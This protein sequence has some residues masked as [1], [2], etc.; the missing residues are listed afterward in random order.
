MWNRAELKNQAKESF[1]RSYWKAVLVGLLC[2]LLGTSPGFE[3]NL[4][5]DDTIMENAAFNFEVSQD[6]LAEFDTIYM[7]LYGDDFEDEYDDYYKNDFFG[8]EEDEDSFYAFSSPSVNSVSAVAIRFVLIVILVFVLGGSIAILLNTFILNPLK[9]GA[10]RFFLKNLDKNAQIGELG[11]AFDTEYKNVT[12]I[13]F[14]RSL[15]TFLWSLLFIIPGIIKEYE[16]QMIPYLLAENPSLTKEQAFAMS[17]Q[18]MDGQKWN[19]FV[20]DLSFF[21]WYLLGGMTLGLLSVFYVNP[22]QQL[23][24]A[25]LYQVLSKQN[26][27]PAFGMPN[28]QAHYEQWVV[29]EDNDLDEDKNQ[30]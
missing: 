18:M 5:L 29:N 3:L 1:K 22:Y 16:Y 2:I 26:G 10:S 21:G 15:Y 24:G 28:P 19:A 11:F 7:D 27:N 4:N 20:L 23:T 9:V 30:F 6:N 13:M 17:K 12:K 25:A 14:F 8:Y